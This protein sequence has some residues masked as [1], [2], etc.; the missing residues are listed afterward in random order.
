MTKSDHVTTLA[1]LLLAAVT[2]QNPLDIESAAQACQ[3]DAIADTGLEE[4][5]EVLATL[6]AAASER[7]AR[8]ILSIEPAEWSLLTHLASTPRQC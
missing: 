5:I 3:R 1:V 8:G 4:R 7:S 6:A 2:S